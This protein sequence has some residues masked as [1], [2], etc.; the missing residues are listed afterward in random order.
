VATRYAAMING[1][2]ELAVTNLDGLDGVPSVKVCTA[3][4]LDGKILRHPPNDAG[5]WARCRPV[6]RTFPG[7]LQDTSKARR[8]S[9]LPPAARR[10]V[11]AL[12]ELT[13]SKLRIVS[14]GAGHDETIRL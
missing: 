1:I 11:K 6:Y 3:Y 9:Q 13:G 8:F 4:K 12:A 14:V 2:D 7:W 10:Y 5:A